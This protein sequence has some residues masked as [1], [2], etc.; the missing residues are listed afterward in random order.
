MFQ[1]ESCEMVL[2]S[3]HSTANIHIYILSF[4][5]DE[6]IVKTMALRRAVISPFQHSAN[7]SIMSM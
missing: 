3:L 7:I 4:Y 2:K 1:H 6:A 5:T